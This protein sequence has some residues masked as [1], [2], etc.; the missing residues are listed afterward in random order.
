MSRFWQGKSGMITGAAPG[1][2]LA[3]SRA[4]VARGA[5]VWMAD[6]D[7][8]KVAEAA[9]AL[10]EA[11]VPVALDVRDAAAVRR[12]VED[13]VAGAGRLDFLVNNA[14][15]GVCGEAHELAMRPGGTPG[16]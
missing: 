3:L 7:G 6:V 5:R 8:A 15:I 12:A 9:S 10:G 13:V 11:A 2:G 16:A 1:I 14:G 4:L